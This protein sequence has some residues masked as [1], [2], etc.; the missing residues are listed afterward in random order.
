MGAKKNDRLMKLEI[1]I[2]TIMLC[3]AFALG[4]ACKKHPIPDEEPVQNTSVGFRAK[5]QATWV[6]SGTKA[7][8]PLSE[9]NI[10]DFG[11][12]GIARKSE[13]VPYVLWDNNNLAEVRKSGNTDVY[14]PV[15][16]AYWFNGFTYKFIA[17]AP[18]SSGISDLGINA[19]TDV[20]SFTFDM[21]QKYVSDQDFDL[22]GAVAESTASA[23]SSSS[24]DLTFWHLLS[25]INIAVSFVDASGAATSGSVSRI[26]LNNIDS[27]A[28]Y[29]IGFDADKNIDVDCIADAESSQASLT[30][31]DS[32]TATMHIVP[33]NISDFTLYLDFTMEGVTYSDFKVN[34]S[35]GGNNPQTYNYNESYNWNITIGPKAAITFSVS[36]ADW[37]TEKVGDEVIIS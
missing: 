37:N 10:T 20:L 23:T 19:T 5:S 16:P 33:Q 27:E 35:A 24:Q 15:S 7:T 14:A 9:F 8:K 22:M 32:E 12:W 28:I 26:C 3:A 21:A 18:F 4:T 30:F 34:L 6:K 29:T 1:R 2:A 25:K 36:I 17:I 13:Q 11:V 31:T